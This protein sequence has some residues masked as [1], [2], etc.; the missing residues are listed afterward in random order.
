M[1][2]FTLA[3]F[4]GWVFWENI[5]LPNYFSFFDYYSF[6]LVILPSLFLIGTIT[7]LISPNGSF[8]QAIALMFIWVMES[9]TSTS[10]EET[11]MIGF[12]ATLGIISFLMI[13]SSQFCPIGPGYVGRARFK[14]THFT[15][16]KYESEGAAQAVTSRDPISMLKSIFG[17]RFLPRR[18]RILC[19]CLVVIIMVSSI[20]LIS[21][22]CSQI[23]IYVHSESLVINVKEVTVYLD[24]EIKGTVNVS[25]F[26][27][28]APDFDEVFSVFPGEHTVRVHC[29]SGS[30]LV[31]SKDLIRNITLSPLSNRMAIFGVGFV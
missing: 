13:F 28:S 4:D 29:V 6:P 9:S 21:L 10:M 19:V 27:G 3:Y 7:A 16:K 20:I 23:R 11:K 5:Y 25:N 2:L 18:L 12:G 14:E 8:I 24:G 30:S 22:P 1:G 15:F 17:L 31:E 26:V